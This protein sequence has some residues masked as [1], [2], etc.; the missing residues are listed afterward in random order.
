MSKNKQVIIQK[1]VVTESLPNTVFRVTL[2]NGVEIICHL[3]G[4]MRI[5]NIKVLTGDS[6]EC[7]M[8][9]F[10]LTKGRICKRLK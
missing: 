3:S 5:N 6:I 4:R 10:D 1:G 9:P 7:E 8:S 2:E